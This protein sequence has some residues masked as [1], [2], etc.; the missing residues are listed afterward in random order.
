MEEWM[1]KVIYIEGLREIV[2]EEIS[3]LGDFPIQ[4]EDKDAIYLEYSPL[5]RILSNLRSALRVYIVEEGENLHPLYLSN[6]K[7]RLGNKIEQVL[8]GSEFKTFKLTCAGHDSKE[9]R[10]IREYIGHTFN[11][12]EAEDADLETY[13]VKRGETWEIGV[14][15]TSRPLS[16]RDYRVENIAGGLNPTIAYAMNVLA[17]VSKAKSYLNV[18]S[19]SGTLLIEAARLNNV[20]RL[21]GFDHDKKHLTASIQN[22]K[23]AGLI[24][25]IEVKEGDIYKNPS[26]G[27]FDIVT[28]DLPFGMAIGKRVDLESLYKTFVEYVEGTLEQRGT[29]VAY[30]TEHELLERVISTSKFRVVKTL[31]LK[32]LSHV[33]AYLRPRILVC[34]FKDK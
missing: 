18:F 5:F 26:F 31:E 6:H 3:S 21:I 29:L 34:E 22:I 14:R 12:T 19:G 17:D 4:R 1:I 25:Q 33:D 7:A 23:K 9:A 28:S 27:K 24:K 30:T 16:L 20:L 10:E 15:T 2:L 11:L 32:F 13:I 8:E